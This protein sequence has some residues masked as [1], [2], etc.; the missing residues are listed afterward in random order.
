MRPILTFNSIDPFINLTDEILN[1]RQN[2]TVPYTRIFD[3]CCD[4]F[5][6]VLA[7][8]D[9]RISN[10]FRLYLYTPGKFHFIGFVSVSVLQRFNV[11][12][13]HWNQ[14]SPNVYSFKVKSPKIQNHI[15]RKSGKESTCI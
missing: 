12:E 14:L 4:P 8:L 3:L 10:E 6:N 9:S 11:I 13:T 7:I 2:A 5:N 15:P 1:L